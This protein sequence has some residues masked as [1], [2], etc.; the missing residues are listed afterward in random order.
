MKSSFF[1]LATLAVN[2]TFRISFIH[3]HKPKQS[4]TDLMPLVT[5][6]DPL[7]HFSLITAAETLETL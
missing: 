5:L 7:S 6:H 1:S 2:Q 3:F 4:A